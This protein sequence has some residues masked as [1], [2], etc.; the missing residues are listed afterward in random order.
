[1]TQEIATRLAD[2]D[3]V[4]AARMASADTVRVWEMR[5]YCVFVRGN[6]V[7]MAQTKGEGFSCVGSSGI[8]TENGLAYLVWSDGKTWLASHGNMVEADAAQVE[9]IRK[10]S[11]DLTV[12]LGLRKEIEPENSGG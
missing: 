2:R 1:M 7:A 4:M 9:S 11:E 12:S 5:E 3:I 6:C 10:F 8:M